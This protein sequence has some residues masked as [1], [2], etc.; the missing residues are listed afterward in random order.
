M[1]FTDYLLLLFLDCIVMCLVV[2]TAF[3]I[4]S[5]GKSFPLK[6]ILKFPAQNL[7][8]KP[9]DKNCSKIEVTKCLCKCKVIS[10]SKTQ[11][12][13]LQLDFFFNTNV[14]S[15]AVEKTT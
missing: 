13:Y 3:V 14:F 12:T 7:F 1:T 10:S 11:V 5:P 2:M 8:V 6:K 15:P 9:A 4:M